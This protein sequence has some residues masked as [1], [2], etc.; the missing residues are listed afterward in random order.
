MVIMP[1]FDNFLKDVRMIQ[2]SEYYSIGSYIHIRR[3]AYVKVADYLVSNLGQVGQEELGCYV[4][5]SN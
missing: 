3:F 4:C 5:V 1:W 2:N